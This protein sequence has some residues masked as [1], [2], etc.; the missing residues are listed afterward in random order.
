MA[1]HDVKL[2]EPEYAGGASEVNIRGIVRVSPGAH[3]S[4]FTP[5]LPELSLLWRYW[6]RPLDACSLNVVERHAFEMPLRVLSQHRRSRKLG[7]DSLGLD[8]KV[9]SVRVGKQGIFWPAEPPTP[10]LSMVQYG[11]HSVFFGD[12]LKRHKYDV[13]DAETIPAFLLVK[14]LADLLFA[15]AWHTLILSC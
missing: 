4:V 1:S 15:D 11:K 3:M 9:V 5:R 10:D 2:D 14:P 12:L 7:T 13:K 8:S 6:Q